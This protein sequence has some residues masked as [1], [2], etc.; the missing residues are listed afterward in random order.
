MTSDDP[1]AFYRTGEWAHLRLKVR[2]RDKGV[3]QY[4]GC[5]AW[6]ADHVTPRRRGGAD[7]KENLVACCT[8]CNELV[9]DLELPNFAEK[10][11]WILAR[12]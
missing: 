7:T 11:A 1:M 12:R 2:L 3:C 5:R 6:T 8:P 9:G 10:R 4:C